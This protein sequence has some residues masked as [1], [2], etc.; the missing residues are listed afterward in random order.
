M[1]LDRRA[2]SAGLVVVLAPPARSAQ[3]ATAPARI[4]VIEND[5]ASKGLEAFRQGLREQGYIEGQTV[6]LEYRWTNGAVAAMPRLAAELAALKVD[7]IFAPTTPAALA[8]L[9]ATRSIPIVFAVAADPIGTHLVAEL[10]KPGGNV[11]G[12][13]TLNLEVAP[14]RLELLKE[15]ARGSASR[16]G[17]LFDPADASNVRLLAELVEPAHQLRMSLQPFPVAAAAELGAAFAAIAAARIDALMVAAGTLTLS[18]V[19][20]VTDHVG[21]AAIPAMYGS[22]EF[23]DAGGLM[24]YSADFADNYRRAAEYVAKILK[25]TPPA[26]LPIEQ[27]S[28]LEFVLNMK[29]ARSLRLSPSRWMLLRATRVIE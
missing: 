21:K 17:L 29:T 22:P 9:N 3:P 25:G 26:S 1:N 12:L 7:V 5:P 14:K 11:T 4:G 23:V 10:A 13:T 19:Q 2:F 20:A 16:C 6:A 24:S 27:V 28:K 8:A 15:I 18:N